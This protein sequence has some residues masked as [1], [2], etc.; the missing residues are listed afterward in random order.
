MCFARF[1]WLHSS[2]N[3]C[4]KASSIRFCCDIWCF[5]H[6]LLSR[7]WKALIRSMSCSCW[8]FRAA[9]VKVAVTLSSF[10]THTL[11]GVSHLWFIYDELCLGFRNNENRHKLDSPCKTRRVVCLWYCC[12]KRVKWV[13]Y[14]T[15]PH[16]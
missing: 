9:D 14:T 5:S 7:V 12:I 6:T 13:T 1:I 3:I 8:A 4:S 11:N 2:Q 10:I 15:K 16:T